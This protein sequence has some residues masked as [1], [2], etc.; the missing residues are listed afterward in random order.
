MTASSRRL[1][2][3]VKI[4][5]DPG[6][7]FED[8]VEEDTDVCLNNED[9]GEEEMIDEVTERVMEEPG[10]GL[11]EFEDSARSDQDSEDSDCDT[12]S[13]MF[14]IGKKVPLLNSKTAIAYSMQH[15]PSWTQLQQLKMV[16]QQVSKPLS[17]S[18]VGTVTIPWTVYGMP[19]SVRKR[20][21]VPPL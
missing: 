15:R 1:Q 17:V 2:S 8:E 19:N 11:I 4:N 21:R 5:L 18:T 3:S 7:E 10:E 20:Q 13:S 12:T 14:G 9:P 16:Y 6:H